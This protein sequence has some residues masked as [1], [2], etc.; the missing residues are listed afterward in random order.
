[1]QEYFHQK[2]V[3]NFLKELKDNKKILPIATNSKKYFLSEKEK[4]RIKQDYLGNPATIS[5]KED[6][7]DLLKQASA[8][9]QSEFINEILNCLHVKAWRGAIVLTWIFT[10][11]HL[12]KVVLNTHLGS[13]NSVNSGTKLYKNLLVTSQ[14]DFEDM[15]EADFLKTIRSCGV[16]NSTKLKLLENELD[17]RN[18]Y[19]HPSDVDITE[20]ITISFIENLIKNIVLKIPL[21]SK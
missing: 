18:R 20:T 3:S 4:D 9:E 19:A 16:I 12:Q 5:I 15:K 1:L 14:V 13:F 8:P 21:A 7:T 11:D 10:M 17:A 2:N 6:L